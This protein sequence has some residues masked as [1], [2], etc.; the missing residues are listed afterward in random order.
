M[1]ELV[2]SEQYDIETRITIPLDQNPAAVYIARLVTH[3]SR[4]GMRWVLNLAASILSN[5]RHDCL[6]LDWANLRYEPEKKT[7]KQTC[8]ARQM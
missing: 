5:G 6:S 3:N 2:K 4:Y 7:K 8:H 1:K